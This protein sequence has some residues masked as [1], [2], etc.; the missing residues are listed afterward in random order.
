MTAVPNIPDLN[1]DP[2]TYDSAIPDLNEY[3]SMI[4]DLNE[5]PSSFDYGI[6]VNT[7]VVASIMTTEKGKRLI[8]IEKKKNCSSAIIKLQQHHAKERNYQRNCL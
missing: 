7:S 4:P 3:P 5:Y 6:F 2:S 1:E 8:D